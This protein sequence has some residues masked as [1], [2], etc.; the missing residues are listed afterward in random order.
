MRNTAAIAWWVADSVTHRLDH[1]S[2]RIATGR[3]HRA[4]SS[5]S[6]RKSDLDRDDR[7]IVA[8]AMHSIR[9]FTST[10]FP[11]VAVASACGTRGADSTLDAP[12]GGG[13]DTVPMI[14]SDAASPTGT[15]YDADGPGPYTVGVEH[16]TNGARTF[17]VTVYMPSAAGA[18]PAVSLASGTNQTA[19]GYAPYAKRLASYGIAVILS[20]DPGVLTNTSDIV[21]DAV[22]LV[23]TWIPTAHPGHFDPSKVGLVGHSRGGAV[24]LLAAEHLGEKVVAWFGLDPVDNE[25]G[26]APREYART[27]LSQLTIP[28]AY[29]GASVTSNCAPVADSY[30]MLYPR[31][32]SPSVLIVGEGAGHTQL[33]PADGCSLC[34]LCSPSGTADPDVVLAYATRYVTAFFARELLGDHGVGAA[35]EGIGAAD[36]IAAHR[37]TMSSK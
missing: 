8:R 19:A 35:F 37:V 12:G 13:A 27:A 17:D 6:S 1:P 10:W 3:A 33:E 23:D 36:D 4:Q 28:T 14:G 5:A 34:N 31:S 11:I 29:L 25:F 26:Q 7:T 21:P 2:A 32:P 20:D 16:V 24:S 15:T 22:F 18:H 30:E 9:A